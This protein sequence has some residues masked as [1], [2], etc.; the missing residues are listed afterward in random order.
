M[1]KVPPAMLRASPVEVTLT[2]I[3]SPTL[4]VA[5][6]VAVIITIATLR[7]WICSTGTTRSNCESRFCMAWRVAWLRGASPEP[8]RPVTM[9]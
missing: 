6:R 7:L 3:L 9:P 1:I 4:A 8:D 5:G 2:S